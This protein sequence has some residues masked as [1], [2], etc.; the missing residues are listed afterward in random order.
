MKQL[1]MKLVVVYGVSGVG[2]TI[3]SLTSPVKPIVSLDAEYS[4]W[5]YK[6]RFDFEHI[7]CPTW[8]EFAAATTKI[9]RG[10]KHYGTIVIDGISTVGSWLSEDEFG[11]TKKAQKVAMLTWS[12]VRGRIKN[13]LLGLMRK[14]DLLILTAEGKMAVEDGVPVK[15]HGRNIT[16]A[17]VNPAVYALADIVMQLSSVPNRREP[18]GYL[19]PPYNKC[20]IDALP[21]VLDPATWPKILEYLENPVDW[22]NLT[23]EEKINGEEPEI[24]QP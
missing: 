24:L 13:L 6:E 14:S 23:P 11:K 9:I 1:P 21:P 18:I 4:A 16:I 7:S 22:D 17:R 20:R 2:K 15:E 12:K 19:R 5:P 3:F 10:N 8:R